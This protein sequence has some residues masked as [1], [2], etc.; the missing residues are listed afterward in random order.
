MNKIN[1][2]KI[3]CGGKVYYDVFEGKEAIDYLREE[4]G[5]RYISRLLTESDL[6]LLENII[7]RKRWCWLRG[8]GDANTDE[9]DVRD[10]IISYRELLW[11]MLDDIIRM[12]RNR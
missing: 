1:E 3:C 10:Y 5:H 4:M 9:Y 6:E 12:M 2:H 8:L 11:D 7:W